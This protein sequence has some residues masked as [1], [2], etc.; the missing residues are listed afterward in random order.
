MI[1]V[2][3][4]LHA[5][6]QLAQME[7]DQEKFRVMLLNSGSKTIET[8]VFAQ[9]LMDAGDLHNKSY[10]PPA[11]DDE[12]GSGHHTID[13]TAAGEQVCGEEYAQYAYI[14]W[15][16]LETA[17]N[18]VL[19][20]ACDVLGLDHDKWEPIPQVAPTVTVS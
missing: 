3:T 5:D 8:K 9:L 2:F 20:W 14:I 17:W 10:V 16:L 7:V 18:D 6:E 19:Y 13:L 1:Q 4:D 11:D 12:C 15:L